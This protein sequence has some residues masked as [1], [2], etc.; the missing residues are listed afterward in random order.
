MENLVL[1][2]QSERLS[3][4]LDLICRTILRVKACR[5]FFC[6]TTIGQ[7]CKYAV[8]LQAALSP[9]FYEYPPHL[10]VCSSSCSPLKIKRVIDNR[11]FPI[12]CIKHE[13]NLLGRNPL[14]FLER[15]CEAQAG[16]SCDHLVAD[17]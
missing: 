4:N 7:R 16:K 5:I 6:S 2:S 8:S 13:H 12:G 10:N 3:W 14:F 17:I 1:V 9:V 11:K 15:H